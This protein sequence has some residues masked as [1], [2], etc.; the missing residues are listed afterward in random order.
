VPDARGGI[1]EL[2]LAA[3]NAERMLGTRRDTGARTETTAR[4]NDGVERR[5]FVKPCFNG[6]RETRCVVLFPAAPTAEIPGEA[7]KEEH[8]I[9]ELRGQSDVSHALS[10]PVPTKSLRN[11]N[12][13]QRA[14]S[15]K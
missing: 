12:V 7:R 2:R 3:D 6:A 8:Q 1:H 5:G 14:V 4:I 9:K 11:T 10:N 15:P 13:P